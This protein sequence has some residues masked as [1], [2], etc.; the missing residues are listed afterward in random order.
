MQLASHGRDLGMMGVLIHVLGDAANNVGV[1]ISALVIWLAHYD[2]RYYAD[3]AV[4]MGIAVMIFIS[5]IS[6]SMYTQFILHIVPSM[7][8][9]TDRESK[10]DAAVLFFSK[11]YP[12]VSTSETCNM[13]L[14][15]LVTDT[16]TP[17]LRE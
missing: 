2:G 12:M 15:R 13:T 8:M 11:A 14:K 5:S 1:I 3:P 16:I 7:N 10:Y 9:S 17:S 6:L 4:G